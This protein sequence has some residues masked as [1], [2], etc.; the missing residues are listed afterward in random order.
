VGGERVAGLADFY[1]RLWAQGP[2]GATIPLR[3]QRDEDVFDV[4]IRSVDRASLLRKPGS[5]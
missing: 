5:D 2:P 4:E 3:M 1:T